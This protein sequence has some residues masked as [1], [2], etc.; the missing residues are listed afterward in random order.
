MSAPDFS[1]PIIP[2][3]TTPSSAAAGGTTSPLI[4]G[5]MALGG[6]WDRS[7]MTDDDVA[8]GFAALDTAVQL[9]ISD[10]D[11][12]DIYTAGKSETLVGQWL[13]TQP[14]RRESVRLQTKAGIRL[15]GN[16]AAEQA[17]V[18][19]RLDEHTLRGGLEGSLERLGVD[20]VGRF[21]VHRWDPL[22]DPTRVARILDA[23]VDEGLTSGVG[24]SNVSWHRVHMLQRH[25]NH[26]IQAIQMQMSLGHRDF[27]E[28]QI[29]ANHPDA[30]TVDFDEQLLDQA[31]A[32]G[33]EI[34]AWGALDQ[35]RYT[36]PAGSSPDPATAA[37]VGQISQE[38]DT[39]PES[40]VLAWLIRLP[41]GIRPVIGSSNPQRIR[42][43]AQA[44][45]VTEHLTQEHWYALLNS[46]RGNNVP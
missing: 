8:A 43:C 37:L 12:A 18:H 27:V 3:N 6:S 32:T 4:Y 22:A 17:P 29:L 20:H 19:Y 46:A 9:G 16:T 25:L 42:A 33:I 34:Q 41:Q 13:A 11:L 1:T 15:P 23:L 26:P 10:I 5:A 40:V 35:G 24:I 39:T 36:R 45:A 38:L 31:H 28:R 14:D 7:P 2:D 21:M 30:A 44:A